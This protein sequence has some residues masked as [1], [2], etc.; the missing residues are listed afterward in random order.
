MPL[1][2]VR[3]R[4]LN[5]SN[6]GV[7]LWLNR[8]ALCSGFVPKFKEV[9]AKNVKTQN[10]KEKKG[11]IILPRPPKKN[12]YKVKEKRCVY[13][14]LNPYT[15]EFVVGYTLAQKENIRC[16]YKGHYIGRKYK[17]SDMIHQMK[18]LGYHPCYFIL[19]ELCCTKVEAYRAV[20]GWTKIFVEQG[21]INMDKGEI[22]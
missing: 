8:V 6:F 4:V 13:V 9:I 5:R 19:D 10:K 22:A 11:V 18:A 2:S 7:E 12:Q 1:H 15:R 17:T 20:I 14:I 16:A 21:Y 3:F